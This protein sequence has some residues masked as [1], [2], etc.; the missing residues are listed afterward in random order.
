M[1]RTR[2]FD[3]E[4]VLEAAMQLFWEKGYEATSLSDL[5]SRM[6]IQRPSI[7]STFG[8]KKELFEAA[9]RRYTTSRAADI[10][11]RLQSHVSVKQSFA[12]F[13]EEV[14][15]AEYTKDLSN[16]C[17]CINTM[18]ELAPHDERFEILTREHQ[19]YLAVIFQETIERGVQ[20]GELEAD[21][22][23]KSL[24]QALIVSLIGLTVMMKSQPQR[25]F[26]DN[27]IAT[28]LTLLK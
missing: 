10:R 13:F 16:G 27:A 21:T 11:A 6:G 17:F 20:A 9:L 12:T 24:A 2:E 7:Y 8:D 3:E 4:K 23:A 25:S 19:L 18:V 1:A 15:Q 14:I 26:V 22:D 5:T 28:T